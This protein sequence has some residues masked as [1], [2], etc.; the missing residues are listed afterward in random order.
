MTGVLIKRG[1][2]NTDTQEECY[3]KMKTEFRMMLLQAKE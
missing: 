3:T 1:D 2:L